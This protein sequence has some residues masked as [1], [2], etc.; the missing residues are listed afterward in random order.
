VSVGA[1][2]RFI[3][4]PAEALFPTPDNIYQVC[5]YRFGRDQVM[6]VRGKLPKARYFSF[7]LCN[8]WMESL[9]YTRHRVV[10]NH[11]TIETDADDNFE[12]ALAHSDPGHPN[13]I[14]TSGHHA[15]YL[16]ARSLLLE[17]DPPEYTIQVMYDK[18]WAAAREG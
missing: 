4:I 6:F 12:I 10:L 9:D 13:W 15:G 2:N 11:G 8:V 3:Q 17:G 16:I 5:W 14:D 18:E 1:L 7:V